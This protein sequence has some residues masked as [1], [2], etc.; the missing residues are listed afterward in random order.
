[1]VQLEPSSDDCHP[2]IVPVCVPKVNR[3][4]VLPEQIVV[5][6]VTVPGTAAGSTV[7]VAAAAYLMQTPL[8]TTALNCVVAVNA[9]DVKVTASA[10][11]D[12]SVQSVPFSDDCHPVIVPVYDPK[13]K[14]PLVLPEQIVV[15]PVT[16]PPTAGASTVTVVKSEF[17]AEQTPL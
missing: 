7:T 3:P 15:P 8:V 6:P 5:P 1:M 9:P 13:V 14:R 12:M 4:L 17:A 16:V 11:P 2:A 10:V